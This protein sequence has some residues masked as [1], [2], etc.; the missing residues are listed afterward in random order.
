MSEIYAKQ[1]LEL[2]RDPP[3]EGKLED[4]EEFSAENPKCGDRTTIYIRR[5]G[6]TIKEMKHET[7]GCA[8]STAAVS[9]L[10]EHIG[11]M[12]IQEVRDLDVEDVLG[13][14]ESDV[15]ERRMSCVALGLRE[16]ENLE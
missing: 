2:Y 6:D 16:L 1:I 13:L 7:K 8:I 4:A 15:P 11:G 5:D 14:L 10:S 9:L 3:N 12:D